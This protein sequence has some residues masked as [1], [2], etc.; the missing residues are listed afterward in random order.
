MHV[1]IDCVDLSFL[2]HI[3]MSLALFLTTLEWAGFFTHM[4]S[5]F[6][7][8]SNCE[9]YQTV[10]AEIWLQVDLNRQIPSKKMGKKKKEIKL[11]ITAEKVH[12]FKTSRT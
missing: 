12:S 2:K 5:P 9:K 11:K 6:L 10:K 3:F 8:I 1:L 4:S 7:Q